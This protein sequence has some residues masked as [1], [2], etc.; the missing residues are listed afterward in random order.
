MNNNNYMLNNLFSL[1]DFQPG[2]ISKF[3]G[4]NQYE[5][6]KKKMSK[7]LKKVPLPAVFVEKMFGQVFELLNIDLRAVL[8]KAWSASPEFTGFLGKLETAPGETSFVPLAD[9]TIS[10]DHTPHLKSYVNNVSI[11]DIKFDINFEFSIKG[12]IL[13]V[14]DQQIKDI[15]LGSCAGK[16]SIKFGEEPIFEK[17]YETFNFMEPIKLG[18]GLPLNLMGKN[19]RDI[20]NYLSTDKN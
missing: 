9:H 3:A 16:C 6:L 2:Q 13:K 12:G 18:N 10:S 19:I 11:G 15:T 8:L 5:Q 17:E 7:K 4:S 20:S 1:K 14:R